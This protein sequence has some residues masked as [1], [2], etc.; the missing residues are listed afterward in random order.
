MA[1]RLGVLRRVRDP[2]R[3]VI[4]A[5]GRYL[6]RSTPGL[7]TRLRDVLVGAALLVLVVAWFDFRDVDSRVRDVETAA[8]PAV[9]GIANARDA[10]ARAELA[11]NETFASGRSP[12]TGPGEDYQNQIAL[13]S[14]ALTQVAEDNVAGERGRTLLRSVQGLLIDY[15]G[16]IEQADA[17]QD[18][19]SGV[20]PP[21][22]TANLWYASGL[23][24]DVQ[25]RLVALSGMQQEQMLA[26]SPGVS[27]PDWPPLVLA[28]ALVALLVLTQL[29]LP[30]RFRRAVN[31]P[32][33]AATALAVT[34]AALT[35]ASLD[36][37]ADLGA[38]RGGLDRVA[39]R[40]A[41]LVTATSAQGDLRLRQFLDKQCATFACG[42]GI[43]R[44]KP[45]DPGSG[46]GSEAAVAEDTAVAT[47]AITAAGI[48]GWEPLLPVAG[49][50]AAAFIALGFQLRLADYRYERR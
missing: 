39:A 15:I 12:L 2:P 20:V 25:A 5:P 37:R 13:A 18:R 29:W 44:F 38:A 45:R 10:L 4:R 23:M 34:L 3:P 21:L 11:V 48:G 42:T 8:A 22:A 41:D 1:E 43:D 9:L 14:Q 17:H 35:A 26:G 6:D 49:L 50:G 36:A 7:L 30:K 32:L 19:T 24:D 16:L 28:V 27:A 47:D 31:V 46:K 33:L 40:Q